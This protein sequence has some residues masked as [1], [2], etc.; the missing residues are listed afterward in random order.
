M[1][2]RL[3]SRHERLGSLA[4]LLSMRWWAPGARTR[5]TVAK[6]F[7]RCRGCPRPS[8]DG[9]DH[10]AALGVTT[11]VLVEVTPQAASRLRRAGLT[12]ALPHAV[13]TPQR[14]GSGTVIRS[15]HRLSA[16][17]E[18]SGARRFD[19]PVAR[20]HARGSTYLL[21]AVHTCP[22]ERGLSQAWRRH[23]TGLERWAEAQPSDEPV[24]LA[25]D[26]NASQA[27]PGFRGML[28]GY[29]DAQRAAGGRWARTWPQDRAI[30]PFIALD[31]VLVRGAGVVSA[32]LEDIPRSDHAAV[33]S[34]L[35]I[36]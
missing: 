5:P 11:L 30:P 22:P 28:H 13:G 24:V 12:N 26:F 9:R 29:T 21:R 18:T 17:D 27:H 35:R 4:L 34:R 19:Q 16:V 3:R 31:H 2:A 7:D 36:G 25:G 33:W 20:V 6:C 14:G 32:G 8:P 23:L 1:A 15:R 10:V